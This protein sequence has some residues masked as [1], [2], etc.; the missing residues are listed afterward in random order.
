LRHALGPVALRI[1]HVGSTAVPGL[2]AKPVIDIQVSVT[3]LGP[4]APYRVPLEGA[5]FLLQAANPDRSK[6]FFREPSGTRRAHVHVRPAGSFEEQLNLLFR[7]FLRSDAGARHEYA[8]TKRELA[9]RFRADREGYVRAKEPTVWA[10]LLRAHDWLQ[11]TNWSP[12]PSD[13]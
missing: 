10:I 2:D 8:R 11:A 13:A 9:E 5:G 6:R 7:D 4:E 3:H 12:G 1:D